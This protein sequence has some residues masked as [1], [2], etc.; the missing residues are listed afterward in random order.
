MQCTAKAQ[1]SSHYT[2]SIKRYWTIEIGLNLQYVKY[3]H[4]F[5]NTYKDKTII[6]SNKIMK[7]SIQFPSRNLLS[8]GLAIVF[9]YPSVVIKWDKRKLYASTTKE[10]WMD[11]KPSNKVSRWINIFTQ[12]IENNIFSF[13]RNTQ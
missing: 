12:K 1:T 7:V 6:A 5:S 2:T 13:R 8:I 10:T 3:H 4:I 9:Q 11:I